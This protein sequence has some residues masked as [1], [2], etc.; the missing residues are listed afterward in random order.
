[1][2]PNRERIRGHF[3]TNVM[4]RALPAGITDALAVGALVTCGEVFRIPGT[5]IATA[6]TMLLSA[7]G[8]MILIKISQPFNKAKYAI[9]IG[10]ICGLIFCGIFLG[11]L[12]AISAMSRIC[13]LLMI[14]FTFAAESLFRYLTILAGKV[15]KRHNEK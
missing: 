5:D 3:M 9:V 13:V 10:N 11:Q 12:F 14:V 2:E 4:L 8:F 1:M 6:S 7:V 15:N